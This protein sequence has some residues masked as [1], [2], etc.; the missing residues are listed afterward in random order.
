MLP[1]GRLYRKYAI[2]IVATV[3]VAL[4]ASVT[5]IYFTQH[6][7]RARLAV[8]QHDRAQSAMVHHIEGG[9]LPSN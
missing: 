2:Y 7:L 1:R 8:S 3:C 9:S 4:L 5:N 6:E